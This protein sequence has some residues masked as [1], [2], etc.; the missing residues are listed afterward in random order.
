M[1]PKNQFCN[2]CKE[3]KFSTF[4]N[5]TEE[6][7]K[8]A[9]KEE[10]FVN[11]GDSLCSNCYN[12]VVQYDR[13]QKYKKN[14]NKPFKRHKSTEN[15]ATDNNN[16]LASIEELQNEITK[17]KKEI[18]A[19]T[20][21]SINEMTEEK[22]STFRNVTEEAKKKA[23]KEEFFVNFGDSL[24]SNCYNCVVQYDR[25]QKYKKNDN[26]PFKR[27]KSTENIA[28]DNNNSL[29]SIEELQNEITKLKKEIEALTMYSINEMTGK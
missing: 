2:Y 25:N 10:F 3:E 24:C 27:H 5:V 28:T 26:K 8:K 14:D 12:C 22:F 7:K 15:I 19:L 29:A 20:M 13:N 11:F 4:R 9:N 1:P 21:Y 23:N 16:S 18:E 17:L 6:A